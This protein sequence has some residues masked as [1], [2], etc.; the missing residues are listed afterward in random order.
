MQVMQET[1]VQSLG[2]EDPWRR[3]WQPTPVFLPGESHGQK[4]LMSYNPRGC[5]ESDMTDHYPHTHTHTHTSLYGVTTA[6][7]PSDQ[8]PVKTLFLAASWGSTALEYRTYREPHDSG[9]GSTG[10]LLTPWGRS[11]INEKVGLPTFCGS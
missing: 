9:L 5:K 11:E 2:W 4:N 6:P 7:D 10:D 1:R 3:K 8:N